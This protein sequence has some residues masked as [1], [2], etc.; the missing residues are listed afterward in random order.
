MRCLVD[1][2]WLFGL[3]KHADHS[4]YEIQPIQS[5]MPP[6]HGVGTTSADLRKGF[7]VSDLSRDPYGLP[8]DQNFDLVLAVVPIGPDPLDSEFAKPPIQLIPAGLVRNVWFGQG[9][10]NVDKR[11]VYVKIPSGVKNISP[12]TTAFQVLPSC[13]VKSR[14]PASFFCPNLLLIQNRCVDLNVMSVVEPS[15]DTHHFTPLS[16]HSTGDLHVGSILLLYTDELKAGASYPPLSMA[17]VVLPANMLNTGGDAWRV[18]AAM[19][20][21]HNNLLAMQCSMARLIAT[22]Y[23]RKCPS[24]VRKAPTDLPDYLI[25]FYNTTLFNAAHQKALCE[26]KLS[27]SSL[28]AGAVSTS[29][30]PAGGGR[31]AMATPA[32]SSA[33]GGRGGAAATPASSSAGGGRGG[34]AAT[35]AS[36]SAGGGGGG[37]A[38][39]SDVVIVKV[40]SKKR[41]AE[42]ADSAQAAKKARE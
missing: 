34:A 42:G 24:V 28:A 38:A 27:S 22:S 7:L 8:Y 10:S 6:F 11:D 4:P 5:R 33:G 20:H 1:R 36:S 12:H 18:H 40:E 14:V 37:A 35:P 32:S 30:A 25:S 39:S 9:A 41:D 13:G 29:S 23:N 16:A 19:C 2:F 21:L 17:I 15:P 31:G 26:L 3:Y